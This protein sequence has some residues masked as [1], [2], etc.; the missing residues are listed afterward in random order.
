MLKYCNWIFSDVL[1]G[2]RDRQTY[3][4]MDKWTDDMQSQDC[5]K[6]YSES[7]CKKVAQT[8]GQTEYWPSSRP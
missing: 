3:R 6:N 1:D 8:T 2:E 5:A 7:H 4:Q